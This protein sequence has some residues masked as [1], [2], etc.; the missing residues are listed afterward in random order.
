ME[1]PH[2]RP[3]APSWRG[4]CRDRTHDGSAPAPSEMALYFLAILRAV[5]FASD[6]PLTRETRDCL[7][8]ARLASFAGS[9]I[10][11]SLVMPE[12][13]NVIFFIVSNTACAI[14]SRPYPIALSHM[15]A[16]RSKSE[17]WLRW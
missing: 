8:G 16:M 17:N 9:R 2:R 1:S 6:P 3:R 4:C 15:P 13:S 5:S 14:S 12:G 10:V 11:Y 7:S